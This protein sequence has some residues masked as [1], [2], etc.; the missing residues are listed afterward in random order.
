MSDTAYRAA[1]PDYL[2]AALILGSFALF[3]TAHLVHY[4]V[5]LMSVLGV[6]AV[7]RE[8]ARLREP[9]VRTLLLLFA[10]IWLPMLAALPDAV[11]P[12][13]TQKTVLLYL[14]LLPAAIY[15]AGA[16]ARPEVLR[17]VTQGVVVLVVFAGL[18][19]FA[20]LIWHEDFFGYPYEDGILKGLFYPKQRLGLFLALFAPLVIDVVRAWC[21]QYP[22]L[23]LLHLPL[24]IVVL[25]SLKRS[26]WLMLGVGLFGYAFVVRRAHDGRPALRAWHVL[27]LVAI[28]GVAVA[29]NPPLRNQIATSA[30]LFS[31]DAAAFDRASAYRLTLWR[32]GLA[33]FADNWLNGVG[34]RGYRSAYAEYAAAD[35]FW[36]ERSGGHGQTHPHQMTIEVA[37]ECGVIGLAGLAMFYV[38]AFGA[39]RRLAGQPSSPVWMLCALVAWF[40][41]N[42]H[43]A[44]YGS[45]WSTLV[46]MLLA[47]ALARLPQTP[48]E[49]LRQAA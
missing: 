3:A 48:P 27:L 40:P 9:G 38:V 10:C 22:P 16:C 31:G 28:A 13:R 11:A 49:Q 32:D 2:H 1:A 46:W 37:A 24:L 18:D 29:T 23:W 34:P 21:R 14:H 30:G 4:P 33:M 35:D 19:A 6:A 36:L 41:L 47:I 25:V 12:T 45:Y 42:A 44:F 7:V 43:L 39:W 15:L 26:A 8:P 17:L 20:Q 5:A